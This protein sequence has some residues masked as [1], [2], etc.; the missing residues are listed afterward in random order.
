MVFFFSFSFVLFY[1]LVVF[2]NG[3]FNVLSYDD[4]CT[5]FILDSEIALFCYYGKVVLSAIFTKSKVTD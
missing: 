4:V 5:S 3:F 2:S 1:F